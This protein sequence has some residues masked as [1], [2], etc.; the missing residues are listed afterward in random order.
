M[1]LPEGSV[2]TIIVISKVSVKTVLVVYGY[3]R[4]K[5]VTIAGKESWP[6]SDNLNNIGSTY[7]IDYFYLFLQSLIF[8]ILIFCLQRAGK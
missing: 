5:P 2:K 4:V 7:S 3:E 6:F 1:D 8:N